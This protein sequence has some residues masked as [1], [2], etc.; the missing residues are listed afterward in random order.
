[1]APQRPEDGFVLMP[2]HEFEAI[3]A[4]C[5]GRRQARTCRCR[6]RRRPGRARP[7]RSALPRG[8][9]PA[10]VPHRDADRRPD[11]HH[12]RH[13]GAA[14]GHRHQAQDLRRQS[15]AALHPLSSARNDPPSRRIF[16]SRRTPMTTT[17]HSHWRDVPESTWRSTS[18]RR[19]ATDLASR[20]SSARPIAAPCTTVRSAARPGRST[21]TAPPSTSQWRTM[22]RC[23]SRRRRGR[24]GSSASASIPVLASCMSTLGPRVSGT[25]GSRSGRQPLRPIPRLR[26]ECW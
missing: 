7:P 9:H 17:F 19:G 11:E 1:M 25:S 3:L 21:S 20:R 8:L 13:A 26:A 18:C 16:R 5:R 15:V 22:I 12:R 24:S 14:G 2:E 10:G 23:R 4:R 6:P